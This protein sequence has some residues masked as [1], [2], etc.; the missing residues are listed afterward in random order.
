[1]INNINTRSIWFVLAGFISVCFGWVTHLW[2]FIFT[3]YFHI[4][5][6]YFHILNLT[7]FYNNNN[8]NTREI[9]LIC[10]IFIFLNYINHTKLR[11]IKF[12]KIK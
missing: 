2:G 7:E 11:N 5:A 8:I 3:V 10:L 6:Q 9:N 12:I 1:M 4:F